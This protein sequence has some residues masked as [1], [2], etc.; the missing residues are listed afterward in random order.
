MYEAGEKPG[1]G[2]Y[3]CSK[4]GEQV[5]LHGEADVLPPCPKCKNTS[6]TLVEDDSKHDRSTDV[7]PPNPNA[8]KHFASLDKD[9]TTDVLPPNPNVKDKHFPK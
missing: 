4:C 9:R 7:L 6:F 2:V 1:T 8:G 5:I 3:T